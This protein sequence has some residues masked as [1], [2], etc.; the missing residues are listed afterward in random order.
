MIYGNINEKGLLNNIA[1]RKQN[2]HEE[3]NFKYGNY[4]FAKGRG[5]KCLFK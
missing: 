4:F 5:F 2:S 3:I 1:N